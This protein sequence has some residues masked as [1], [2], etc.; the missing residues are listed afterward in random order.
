M[1]R[2]RWRSV[3]VHGEKGEDKLMR[4]CAC[5]QVSAK[6]EAGDGA[7]ERWRKADGKVCASKQVSTLFSK[8]VFY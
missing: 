8:H 6:G 5:E 1:E 4:I 3:K 2:M 7:G